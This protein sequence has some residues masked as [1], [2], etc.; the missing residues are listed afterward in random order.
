MFNNTEHTNFCILIKPL[1]HDGHHHYSYN[2]RPMDKAFVNPSLRSL[3]SWRCPESVVY[4]IAEPFS[5]GRW[6]ID[7]TNFPSSSVSQ[8]CYFYE[9]WIDQDLDSTSWCETKVFKPLRNLN[10]K[11]ILNRF[12]IY[13]TYH[14][15]SPQLKSD[16]VLQLSG[17]GDK[18]LVFQLLHPK[19]LFCIL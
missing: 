11:S 8:K 15:F 4:F 5:I 1:T 2:W 18:L 3:Y 12:H 7:S 17:L 9:H 10:S 19:H 13:G 6:N 16:S 14:T